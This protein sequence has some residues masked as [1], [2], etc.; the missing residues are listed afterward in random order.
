MLVLCPSS[1]QIKWRDELH[2]KFGLEFRSVDSDLMHDLRRRRGPWVNP[3]EHHPRLITSFGYLKRSRSLQ[4]FRAQLP[5]P[6]ESRYP[7]RFEG[8][9]GEFVGKLLK[10]LSR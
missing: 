7:R 10:E 1:L 6:R 4:L 3:W 5:G 2:D 9:A 8:F